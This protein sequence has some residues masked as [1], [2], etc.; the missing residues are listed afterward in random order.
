MF[1]A[2]EKYEMLPVSRL[3]S[4]SSSSCYQH[5][6]SISV[7]LSSLSTT[8]LMSSPISLLAFWWQISLV[9]INPIVWKMTTSCNAWQ[10]VGWEI[11]QGVWLWLN[12]L[13]V[14]DCDCLALQ[15]NIRQCN[16]MQDNVRECKT[17]FACDRPAVQCSTSQ[18]S[19]M[20]DNV[21]QCKTM[22]CNAGHAVQCNTMQ[23]M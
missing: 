20:Q 13:R 8:A 1:S 12:M 3:T 2:R 9:F 5:F 6:L 23:D 7:F 11:V 22:P 19:L 18:W 16:A 14:F 10:W 17:M 4:F 21:I 15:C